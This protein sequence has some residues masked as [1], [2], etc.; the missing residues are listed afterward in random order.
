[1]YLDF[2]DLLDNV[3][4]MTIR[5]INRQPNF[6]VTHKFTSRLFF[7]LGRIDSMGNNNIIWMIFGSA[8]KGTLSIHNNNNIDAS[9]DWCTGEC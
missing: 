9:V 5:T 1:M 6:L 8:L 3:D 4:F 7:V 2:T